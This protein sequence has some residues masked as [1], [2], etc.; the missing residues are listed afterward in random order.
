MALRTTREGGNLR[1]AMVRFTAFTGTLR[2]FRLLPSR[3][4]WS[5]SGHG[6]FEPNGDGSP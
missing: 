6:G 3:I 5:C 1:P 2:G 4:D